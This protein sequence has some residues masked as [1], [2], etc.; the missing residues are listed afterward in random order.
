MS[1]SAQKILVLLA[2]SNRPPDKRVYL[3]II[4]RIFQPKHMLWVLKRLNEH[5]QHMFK[6]IGKK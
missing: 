1:E 5:Q 6:F 2:L 4:F 3:K